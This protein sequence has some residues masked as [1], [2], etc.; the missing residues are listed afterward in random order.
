MR[1]SD[2]TSCISGLGLLDNE[3]IKIQYLCL[4]QTLRAKSAFVAGQQMEVKNGLLVFT[5]ENMIFMQQEGYFT[6]NYSQALRIPLE[7]IS[8]MVVGGTLLKHIRVNIG[9]SGYSQEEHFQGLRDSNG[10]VIME[11]VKQN[12]ESV[13][14][15][16][17]EE[18]KKKSEHVQIILD[19][20]SL[21]DVMSKGG[22][23]MTTYKCPNCN[24]MVDIPEAGKILMC[25]YCGTPIKP[26]DIFEKIRGLIT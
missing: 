19:F 20:S 10:L 2:Y 12:I 21:K 26:V 13:L 11:V 8:G 9:T 24:G 7:N 15:N 17:R 3:E 18:Q 16:A 14:K 25:Q 23:V 6:S 22:L 1:D 4:R 5:N